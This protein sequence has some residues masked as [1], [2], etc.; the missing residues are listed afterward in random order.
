M[1]DNKKVSDAILL[2]ADEEQLIMNN[3]G[4]LHICVQKRKKKKQTFP[5]EINCNTFHRK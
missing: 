2:P 4:L 5:N 3:Y 1:K